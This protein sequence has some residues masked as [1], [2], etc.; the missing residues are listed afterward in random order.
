MN[1][2][3]ILLVV[4]VIML[5]MLMV[6]V[7]SCPVPGSPKHMALKITAVGSISLAIAILALLMY[8]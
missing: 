8:P 7:T 6:L 1:T 4:L 5:E 3:L 2:T